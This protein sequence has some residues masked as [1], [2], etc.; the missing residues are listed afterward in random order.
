ME[1]NKKP[2]SSH[3]RAD[4]FPNISYL[5]TKAAHSSTSISKTNGS[6][7]QIYWFS[8]GRSY[9]RFG[10]IVTINVTD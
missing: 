5:Q 7:N 3:Y 9:R 2:Y 6:T 1:S 4:L 8:Y 10:F